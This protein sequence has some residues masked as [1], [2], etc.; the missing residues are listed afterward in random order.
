MFRSICFSVSA[1]LLL[2]TLNI[3][4]AQSNSRAVLGIVEGVRTAAAAVRSVRGAQAIANFTTRSRAFPQ[5]RALLIGNNVVVAPGANLATVLRLLESHQENVVL[6]QQVAPVMQMFNVEFESAFQ[7]DL[8]SVR[9][10]AIGSG[11]GIAEEGDFAFDVP[12][13]QAAADPVEAYAFVAEQ[14]AVAGQLATERSNYRNVITAF[15]DALLTRASNFGLPQLSSIAERVHTHLNA[16]VNNNHVN[17]LGA[18]AEECV[19]GWGQRYNSAVN[20]MVSILLAVQNNTAT[21]ASAADQMLKA[22][23]GLFGGLLAELQGRLSTLTSDRCRIYSD[24]LAVS[25]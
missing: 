13:T 6:M 15:K 18:R 3:Q 10:T 14:P 20:N 19:L 7:R 23:H 21:Y 17:L 8:A 12:E 16:L 2:G 25:A 24:R 9:S 5:I 1:L 4:K 11:D 22:M